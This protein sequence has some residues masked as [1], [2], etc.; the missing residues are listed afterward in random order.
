MFLAFLFFLSA[1][2]KH[3]AHTIQIQSLKING[4]K[5]SAESVDG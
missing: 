3:I 4:G 5:K 1:F 2:D